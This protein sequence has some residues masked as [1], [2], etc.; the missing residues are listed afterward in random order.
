MTVPILLGIFTLVM[1][2]YTGVIGFFIN[3]LDSGLQASIKKL[4]DHVVAI[5]TRIDY[6]NKRLDDHIVAINA[7]SDE[8]QKAMMKLLQERCK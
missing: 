1:T 6:T 2:V 8:L 3:R 5:N 7:R 4:D